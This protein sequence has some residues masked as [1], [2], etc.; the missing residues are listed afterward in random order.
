MSIYFYIGSDDKI[1]KIPE[2]NKQIDFIR[3]KFSELLEVKNLSF[4][5]GSGCSSYKNKGGEEVGIPIME[6]LAKM[7][8]NE[9]DKETK[10]MIKKYQGGEIS[11]P[12]SFLGYLYRRYQSAKDEGNKKDSEKYE[13]AIKDTKQFILKKCKS[14]N[15]AVT[16]IYKNFYRKLLLRSGNLPRIN[17]L[18]TN[19]DLNSE[20]ALDEL[21]V[22]YCNGFSG[23]IE[24][25]FNP[26]VF[27]YGLFTEMDIKGRP[28]TQIDN[29][30]F[31]YKLHGSISWVR[32]IEQK[33]FFDIK[34]VQNIENKDSL[35]VM[36]YPTPQKQE[37]S[38]GVPYS[39]MFREFQNKIGQ[40]N[41][42]LICIGYGFNDDH[43]NNIIF[44]ALTL[45]TFRLVILGD[46][47]KGSVEKLKEL[48]DSRIWIVGGKHERDSLHYFNGFVNH[49]L[50]DIG[51]EQMEKQIRK[52]EEGLINIEKLKRELND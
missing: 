11:N 28:L 52:T 50:P 49:I 34:E 42:V 18:T 40:N 13:N 37:D 36:I 15:Q 1:K 38:F 5:L 12:E 26:A 43:V 29:F 21:S 48:D 17:V 8:V 10:E 41:S 45:P 9:A 3:S 46:S 32:D 30:I 7:F 16:E 4:L 2:E 25:R 22:M 27:K 20:T 39:D 35:N 33:R 47:E 19:Y 44:R 51:Q 31:L 14:T 24:R 23:F 6:G